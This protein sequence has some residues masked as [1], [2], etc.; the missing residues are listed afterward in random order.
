VK[1]LSEV[2]ETVLSALAAYWIS[3]WVLAGAL[4]VALDESVEMASVRVP[5]AVTWLVA[6]MA[7]LGARFL[8]D[9]VRSPALLSMAVVLA[10][11]TVLARE[12]SGLVAPWVQIT[13]ACA[14]LL[15]V[16]GFV[17]PRWLFLPTAA[18]VLALGGLQRTDEMVR[19]DSPVRLG[20][21]LTEGAFVVGLGLLGLMIRA[22]LIRSSER[23]DR[24]L[25]SQEEKRQ[26]AVEQ[27]WREDALR[28]HMSLLHDTALNTLNAIALSPRASADEQRRRCIED[29]RQLQ[30][31][32][33]STA[34]GPQPLLPAIHR[35][36]ARAATRGV[37]V[38][39]ETPGD[40]IET[41]QVPAVV[42]DAL[43]GSLEEALLNVGKHAGVDRA[44]LTVTVTPTTVS[45][46]VTDDGAGFD[47]Q[48]TDRRHGLRYSVE[49]R[50][51][52]VGGSALVTSAPGRGTS[53]ALTWTRQDE[54]EPVADAAS[55]VVLR[56]LG[57]LMLAAT[58]FTSAVVV[59]EWQAF[60]LPAVALGGALLLG[61]WG[62][63]VVYHLRNQRSMPAALGAVTV[64]LA[65]L[66]PFWTIGSDTYCSSTFGTLGWVDPRLPLVVVVILTAGL[67]WHASLAVPA[68]IG[69]T[70]VAATV[71]NGV[72]D[73]CP[74]VAITS[75]S[76]ALAVFVA[77]LVAGRALTRQADAV[78]RAHHQRREAEWDR[79]RAAA[80]RTEQ[81]QWFQ[82]A[83]DSCIPLLAAIGDG[84]ADPGSDEVRQRCRE[85][86]GYLRGLVSAAAAPPG[87]R[88]AVLALL[89][90][91]RDAGLDVQVRGDLA[92]LPAP[93]PAVVETLRSHAPMTLEHAE[94][95]VITGVG[96][97]DRGSLMVHVPGLSAEP[98]ERRGA[99]VDGVEVISD[100]DGWWMEV[101]WPAAADQPAAA[102]PSPATPS[103]TPAP[104]V[105]SR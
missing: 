104:R 35:V 95:I 92:R 89:T 78:G 45:A 34:S 64:V 96:Q 26:T 16:M 53:V 40:P 71:W 58:L 105:A 46:T 94:S 57:A 75:S 4:E 5:L 8:P 39:L 61:G 100:Q 80:A 29:A 70:M 1:S 6:G 37:T 42:L 72:F 9:P 10:V 36:V 30:E 52:D 99:P 66:A 91:A 98:P 85:E 56:L 76:V 83:L 74:S 73:G 44:R 86:S 55:G 102:S 101:S 63:V 65:C 84:S 47:L 88:E 54:D 33:A 87:V 48:T 67:W 22:V 97:P 23:A 14:M 7:L 43:S 24:T 12:L 28:A 2:A 25:E 62:L 41:C 27:R 51:A 59:A 31:G 77:S 18:F 60:R 15:S 50:M 20:V 68:F 11:G 13:V 38:S 103:R 3:L 17:G 81:Q 32:A 69:A 90:R 21:P 49:E 19:E 79:M 82:P 93:S